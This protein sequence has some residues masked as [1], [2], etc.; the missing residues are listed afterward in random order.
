MMAMLPEVASTNRFT[1]LRAARIAGDRS[2][3]GVGVRDAIRFDA[4][5]KTPA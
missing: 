2:P 4:P 1:S 5:R 3:V